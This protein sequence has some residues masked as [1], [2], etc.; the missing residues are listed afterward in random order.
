MAKTIAE[1]SIE[2]ATANAELI[3][4]VAA[5]EATVADL[6]AKLADITA[7]FDAEAA[8]VAQLSADKD[9]ATASAESVKVERDALQAKV[10]ELSKTLALNPVVKQPE[11]QEPVKHGDAAATGPETWQQALAACGGDYVAARTKF[12]AL[13]IDF[14]DKGQK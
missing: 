4:K 13:F 8:K 6:T 11:G 1:K 9:A 5:F 10:E 12:P 2:L 14:T 7:K 3:S